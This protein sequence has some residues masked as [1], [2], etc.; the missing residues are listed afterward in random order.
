M[1][2]QPVVVDGMVFTTYISGA[3]VAWG[4]PPAGASTLYSFSAASFLPSA[5]PGAIASAFGSGM[6]GATV[7]VKDGAGTSTPATVLFSSPG[8]VN[9]LMP[10]DA[11]AGPGTVSV[12]NANGNT[13]S[14]ALQISAVAPGIFSANGNGKGVAAAQ[15]LLIGSDGSGK[16]VAVAQCG[17]AS[18]SCVAQPVSLGSGQAALI[19]YGTGIR[20]LSSLDNVR[21]IIGGV[22]APV[23]YAGPQN[24]F[25][26]LDQ[27]NV[28]IPAELAGRGEVN[29]TLSVD[30]QLSNT[31]TVSFQ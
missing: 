14:T 21:C 11:A 5:A 13:L 4:I 20:G 28:Q 27:V 18:G 10:A 15:V 23:L 8:Q 24:G 26:G 7:T 9:F 12:T 2:S 6:Q 30:G 17:A 31:V 22:S 25:Q 3:V 19:L 16:Y 1:Y 29:V